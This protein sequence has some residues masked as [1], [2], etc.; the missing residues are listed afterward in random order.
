[1]FAEK[2]VA[3]MASTPESSSESEEEDDLVV[4]LE[5][6]SEFIPPNAFTAPLAP[7]N[8]QE[9]ALV[10]PE[11]TKH[12][13]RDSSEDV[14]LE[15]EALHRR[16]AILNLCSN[17]MHIHRWH[18]STKVF[19]FE[20]VHAAEKVIHSSLGRCRL[21]RV[22]RGPLK[23]ILV[24]WKELLPTSQTVLKEEL[25]IE[26]AREL[27]EVVNAMFTKSK[28]TQ[29]LPALINSYDRIIDILTK[30]LDSF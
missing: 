15:G 28:S 16:T 27:V 7:D 2:G 6:H 24:R 4:I 26:A 23:L 20:A 14:D 22:V 29:S 13:G 30:D 12:D 25:S 21:S 18:R 5:D 17:R 11:V 9:T 3:T 19:T 10:E 1:M 8:P